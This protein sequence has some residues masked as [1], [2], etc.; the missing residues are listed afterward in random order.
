MI[1][2]TKNDD[3]TQNF[4]YKLLD[5]I[6]VTYNNPMNV[7]RY[8]TPDISDEDKNNLW[9]MINVL[10]NVTTLKHTLED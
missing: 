6:N 10:F 9:K 7:T 2:I 5:Y 8:S 3:G 4:R 1:E